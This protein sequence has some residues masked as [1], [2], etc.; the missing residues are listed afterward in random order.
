M[1]A[2]PGRGL[3]VGGAVV[4]ARR[5]VGQP[6][7]AGGGEAVVVQPAAEGDA[8]ERPPFRIAAGQFHRD[9]EGAPA[10]ADRAPA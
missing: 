3:V 5:V 8:V 4:V 7:Q 1:Q 9:G 6:V 2:G 10:I